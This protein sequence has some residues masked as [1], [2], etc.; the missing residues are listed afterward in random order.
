MDISLFL[1]NDKVGILCLTEH[2]LKQSELS[3]SIE[4]YKLGSSF[5][6]ESAIRGGSL[7]LLKNSIKC[8]ERKDIVAF[9]VE[10]TIEIS[11]VE[12]E[13]YI[14]V[15][16]YRP[17]SGVYELFECILEDVLK[18]VCRSKKKVI[19][20]GDFNINILD[21]NSIT[22]RFLN[23]LRSFNL[24]N[25]FKEPTRITGTSAT[26]IDNIFC[27]CEIVEKEIFTKLRSDHTG[28]IVSLPY[29][30]ENKERTYT[31]RPVTSARLTRF[32]QQVTDRLCS[33][34][35]PVGNP[36]DMYESLFRCICDEYDS[37]F[38]TK[39]ARE[40][41]EF[42]QWATVGIH[43]S[44]TTLYEL[45]SMKS[46]I[47][48]AHFLNHVRNYSKLFKKVCVQAK[49]LHIKGR[50]TRAENKVKATWK[51]INSEN[52]KSKNR[53][54]IVLVEND[55]VIKSSESVAQVFENFFSS[56]PVTTTATLDSCP[57][58]ALDLLRT[59]V[60]Q[61]DSNFTF[62][63]VFPSTVIGAFKSLKLKGTEDLWG[64]SVQALASIIY[65]IAP[66]LAEIFNSCIDEGKFPDLLKCSKIIP[67][68]KSGNSEDPTNYRPISILP[69]LSKVFE[70]L[71]LTQL[72]GHFNRNSI[73]NE[74]QYGFTQGR[75]TTD[76]GRALIGHIF[77]AWEASQN[78]IGVFCDLSKAFDCVHH[79]ILLGKLEHYGIKAKALELISSYLDNRIQ[80]V[81]V[82]GT[83][84]VGSIMKMGV[85]QGSILGPF[86]FL[87]YINDLPACIG[88]LCDVVLFADDT[89]LI[90]KTDRQKDN[91]DDV[92]NALSQVMN[93]FSTNNLLL[94]PKKTKCLKFAL[95]NVGHLDTRININGEPLEIVDKA[96]FLG[97]TLDSKLQWA[98]H[99]DVLSGRLSS[100][101][102]AVR[103]I[104][105]L[106]DEQT[107]KLVYF[108]YFHSVMSYGILMW[109][110]AA[111]INNIFVLQKRAIR[112]I[113]QLGSRESLREKFKEIKVMTVASQYIY[114]NI[115]YV[116]KNRDQFSKRT[117][118]HSI[119]T[120]NKHKLVAPVC[121]L[122][123]VNSSFVGNC[124]RFFNKIPDS[125]LDLGP[126]KFK[127]Y[128]KDRLVKKA[129]YKVSDYIS[130]NNVWL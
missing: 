54:D 11:C 115:M 32:E 94:N 59:S 78:A 101:A 91:Y 113:Y 10:R 29:I 127:S 3:F 120:R 15:C 83:K 79:S 90:F 92:S 14:V 98:P 1:E 67:L 102:F 88:D 63:H 96:V 24:F 34:P 129:Y 73:M 130:D 41:T 55:V 124:I 37:I 45:Y 119:N 75:S 77:D 56:I 99:I 64:V 57:S 60:R 44:R 112:S 118:I 50:I 7:I 82:Q 81:D 4:H 71:I 107:A 97:I 53:D 5:I 70:K 26:C 25:L 8:K 69:A 20:C 121:R 36:D 31:Y 125:V 52:G 65:C 30:V 62:Q 109:G 66:R 35:Q 13:Q 108:S 40:K 43:R 47:Q 42:N 58:R 28:Q 116:Y 123:R 9:S 80:R 87:V 93:W 89:S 74:K 21:T 85:P 49:A 117:D 61:C 39:T 126:D 111:D 27:N 46:Y 95:P 68:F 17:P 105:Q 22:G 12:L 51:V 86:L 104:R 128:I 110:R 23:L 84:S 6:R 16:V 48:D 106:T 100:A 33:L 103:R 114:A 38:T 72:L 122:A 19:V 2:W 76:A 18:S